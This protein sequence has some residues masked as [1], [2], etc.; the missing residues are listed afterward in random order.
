MDITTKVETV[1]AQA[2]TNTTALGSQNSEANPVNANTSN[3]TKVNVNI[4]T[5]KGNTN[6]TIANE[7]NTNQAAQSNT[8]PPVTTFS[9]QVETTDA[10]PISNTPNNI[11][12]QPVP[13]HLVD[14][15]ISTGPKG[16]KD[17]ALLL[18]W[19]FIAGFA[20]RFVPDALNRLVSKQG[21][22]QDKNT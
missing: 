13:V 15:L 5:S 12:S 17:F 2:S 1:T 4:N 21:E 10:S 16:G 7:S 8:S 18:I 22:A 3:Q 14:F 6:A 19:C 9:N 11:K 20:E